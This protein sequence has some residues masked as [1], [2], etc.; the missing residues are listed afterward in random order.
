MKKVNADIPQISF[1]C[2]VCSEMYEADM[3]MW[4]LTANSDVG[5]VLVISHDCE[6][7]S[8]SFVAELNVSSIAS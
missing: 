6:N 7:C 4:D 3:S 2:P 1:D 8:T 5:V